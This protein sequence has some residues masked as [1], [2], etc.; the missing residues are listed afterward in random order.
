VYLCKGKN[1]GIIRRQHMEQQGK[2]CSS[3]TALFSFFIGGLIGAGVALLVAPKTG[4][5]TRGMIREL[6]EDTKAKAADWIDEVKD[7][8]SGYVKKGKEFI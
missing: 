6:A 5:A 3:G 1:K 8:A 7:K 2:G 4:E